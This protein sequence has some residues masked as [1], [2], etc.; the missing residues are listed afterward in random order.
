MPILIKTPV[1]EIIDPVFTKTSQ[2]A[3][4][5]LS[6][7]ER[8]GLVFVKTGSINSG[9][10]SDSPPNSIFVSGIPPTLYSF[11][12]TKEN[13]LHRITLDIRILRIIIRTGC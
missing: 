2:N 1:P 3:R 13:A 11:Y 4:F 10:G 6:E 5:L 7:N 9:T 8:F 12:C